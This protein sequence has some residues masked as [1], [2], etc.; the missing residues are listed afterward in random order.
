MFTNIISE[1]TDQ[2]YKTIH[3]KGQKKNFPNDFDYTRFIFESLNSSYL[4][5]FY[6]VY[7][8]YQ[9]KVYE[10]ITKKIPS[11]IDIIIV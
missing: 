11:S 7:L 6:F 10:N 8:K 4:F 9:I 5:I 3:Q 1:Y 2:F